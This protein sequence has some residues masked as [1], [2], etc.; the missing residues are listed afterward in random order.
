MSFFNT[1]CEML[2]ILFAMAMG[3]LAHRLG[4]FNSETDQRLS[5]V[6][7][8]ITMPAMIVAAVIT[9]DTLPELA[10]VLAVLKVAAVFYLLEM[11]FALAAPRLLGGT[12]GQK[13]V[14]RFG[15]V[16]G[17]IA[18]IGYPVATALF[19]PGALFYAVILAMPFNLLSYTLGPLMLVGAKR[20]QWKQLITPCTTAAV[21]GLFFALTRLRPPALVGEC[22]AFVGNVTVPLSLLV[23]GS[24]LAGLP[25][26]QVFKSPRLWCLSAL[27]LLVLP[28]VLY[29]ILRAL[30]TESLLL[31][32]TVIEMAMPVAI[33][34]S[35][36]CLEYGGDKE[37][38][39][40]ATLL[41]TAASIITIPLIASA[42]L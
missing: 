20:F 33:N 27:R 30:G 2:V 42:L 3:F 15:L 1:L 40:Q 11:V 17:N 35:M 37:C 28:G 6:V 12:P 7:L 5:K 8:N 14:W 16:F 34:G 24:L 18:F 38:M 13:G 26:G 9:G 10:E 23:V 21:L 41:T 22:L 39:A 36:L 19:G 25:M 32:I 4:Y 31:G 29:I